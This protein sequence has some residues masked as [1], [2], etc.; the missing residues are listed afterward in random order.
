M[1]KT[2]NFKAIGFLLIILLTIS[3]SNDEQKIN[4]NE[5]GSP[6]KAGLIKQSDM[7]DLIYLNAV[8]TFQKKENIRVSFEGFIDKVYK[9]IGD[10]INSGDVIFDIKTKEFS[11]NNIDLKLTGNKFTGIIKIKANT[12]GVLTQLN[13]FSGDFVSNGDNLAEIVDPSSLKII[14]NVPYQYTEKLKTGTIC[15][16][17]LPN[18]NKIN[19]RIDKIIPTVDPNYQT[20][21]FILSTV[22]SIQ[23]PDNLNVTVSLPIAVIKNANILPKSAVLTNETLNH[24]WIMKLV[25]DSTAVRVNIKKGIE[26]ENFVQILEPSFGMEDKIVFDGGFGLPDTSKIK[27]IK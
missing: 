1:K 20:Q 4:K 19:A 15:S 3:C 18:S 5:D 24:F 13:F 27:I 14:L 12:N 17:I 26:N 22:N 2:K 23:L 16:I 9:N 8:T 11:G 21:K 10:K 6:V 25:N 7:E